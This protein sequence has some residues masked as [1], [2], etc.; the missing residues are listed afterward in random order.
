MGL[1]YA[2][3]Q[4]VVRL[5][6]LNGY[7]DTSVHGFIQVVWPVCCH[8]NETIVPMEE[9]WVRGGVGGG[10]KGREIRRTFMNARIS[11]CIK[12]QVRG[13]VHQI[14]QLDTFTVVS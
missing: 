11:T 8:D 10:G 3:P 5:A 12:R 7:H 2:L 14:V 1:P 9:W 4:Y 6:E 13:S